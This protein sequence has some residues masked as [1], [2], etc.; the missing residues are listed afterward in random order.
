VVPLALKARKSLKSSPSR[1]A[2]SRHRF[3]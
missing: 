2:R 1:R 3:R